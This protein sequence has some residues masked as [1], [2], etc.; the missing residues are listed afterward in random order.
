MQKFI[1]PECPYPACPKSPFLYRRRGYY[2]RLC[3]PERIPRFQCLTCGRRFSSQT[4]RNDYRHHKPGLNLGIV[5]QLISKVSQRQI[6]RN[7]GCNPKTVARRIPLFG[8][9]FQQAHERVLAESEKLLGSNGHLVFDELETFEQN[10]IEK[11]VTMAVLVEARTGFI[12]HGEAGTLPSRDKKRGDPTRVSQSREVVTRCMEVLARHRDPKSLL[13]VVSDLK[14]T[15]PSIVHKTLGDHV[16]H[17]QVSSRLA[18]NTK[19]P[20]FPIN[21]QFAMLR[22]NIS[23]LVRRNW[24]YSKRIERKQDH[25]WIYLGYKNYI[26][27]RTNRDHRPSAASKLGLVQRR[28]SMAEAIAW[29]GR[30]FLKA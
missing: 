6:A 11:P 17:V 13:V 1:P 18:R 15:Y 29:K 21:H 22:D 24:G 28:L 8:Q 16:V 2:K 10:R 5:D 25:F 19:N 27:P 12:V 4:F 9:H 26:R 7:L 30:F 3:G 23:R 20:L 14:T